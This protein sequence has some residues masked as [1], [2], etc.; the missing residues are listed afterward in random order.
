MV[1]QPHRSTRDR[2]L[3][4]MLTFT[5]EEKVAARSQL[6]TRSETSTCHRSDTHL[7][8]FLRG[9]GSR[10]NQAVSWEPKIA[11]KLLRASTFAAMA[12][13]ACSSA[14]TSEH[15]SST[16]RCSS[17]LFSAKSEKSCPE[18]KTGLRREQR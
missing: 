3:H 6:H 12:G 17:E 10:Y 15:K 9:Q 7:R 18:L 13:L 5:G 4:S 16:C 14:F 1:S 2:K 8:S 11:T